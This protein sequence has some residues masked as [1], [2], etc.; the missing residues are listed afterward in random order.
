MGR[1]VLPSTNRAP[2][3]MLMAYRD[4]GDFDTSDEV[5]LYFDQYTGQLLERRDQALV[6]RA[7]GI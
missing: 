2:V 5:S 4:H 7:P 3:L 1:V 6:N